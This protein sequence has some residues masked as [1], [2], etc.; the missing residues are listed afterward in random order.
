M[1]KKLIIGIILSF[2]VCTVV[3]ASVKL[4]ILAVNP[5]SSEEQATLVRFDLPR[6]IM[7]G[8]VIN[9]GEME[10]R[11]DFDKANYY[12]CREV[13]LEPSEKLIL[14]VELRDIWIIQDKEINFLKNHTGTLM[15]ELKPTRHS[16]VAEALS[17][18]IGKHLDKIAEEQRDTGL[19]V[20]QRIDFYYEHKKILKDVI[21]DIGM[22]ENLVVDTGG[23]VKEKLG[24][25]SIKAVHIAEKKEDIVPAKTVKLSIA[26]TNSA[27]EV[28]KVVPLKYFL[29]REISPR[30][31]VNRGGLEIGYD[32]QE[33][34][35]Y[36]CKKEVELE[37]EE[38]KVFSVEIK[39]VWEISSIKIKTLKEHTQGLVNLLKGT[40]FSS[41]AESLGNKVGSNL[42]KVE[43]SRGE[44]VS[45]DEHIS[46]YRGDIQI[47]EK[48]EKYIAQL[49]KLV[50][51]S[52]IVPP[53][54]IP[55]MEKGEKIRPKGYEGIKFIARSIFKGKAPTPATTWKVIWT[56]I[57]FLAIVSILF[58]MLQF[59]Q[60]RHV[61]FDKLTGAFN[62]EYTIERLEDELNISRHANAK[63]SFLMMDMDKFKK[64]NDEYGHAAGDS[65][66]REFVVSIR[67]C[68]RK[69]DVVG[70][71]GGDEFIVILSSADKK[72]ALKI[73]EQIKTSVAE[74]VFKVKDKLL[75]IT[76]SIGLI[77]YPD[78]STM[79]ADMLLKVDAA[80]Y[81]AKSRG[82]NTIVE[83]TRV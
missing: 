28:S 8:D 44:K 16:G 5:S 18:N 73:A 66:L 43:K 81:Q 60:R 75:K 17:K 6:G 68:L 31:I 76:S 80:M 12:V 63:C 26:I 22:L 14:E 9:T 77:T 52:G 25:S 2:L 1:F 69:S 56:I 61:M 32:L 30:H 40:E 23:F 51:Q 19:P 57:G 4:K 58:F 78:D 34:C 47:L 62:R 82:G 38:T 79:A 70:R 55:I 15:K 29:P 42:E 11:Y 20:K 36:A 54:T 21:A 3:Q 24:T 74:H 13:V 10:L 64:I 53:V 50:V 83:V 49:E 37:P 48:T 67:K 46:R 71:Y 7:P 27:E 41:T 65:V 45:A 59:V 72:H 35:F 39:D 33:E